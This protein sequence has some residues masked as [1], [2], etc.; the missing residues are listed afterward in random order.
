MDS[1]R[2][3]SNSQNGF[4]PPPAV[5][6]AIEAVGPGRFNARLEDGTVLAKSSARPF[7]DACLRLLAEGADPGQTA[8]LRLGAYTL[9]LAPIGAAAVASLYTDAV[10]DEIRRPDGTEHPANSG[11]PAVLVAFGLRILRACAE[12]ESPEGSSRHRTTLA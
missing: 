4:R 11:A 8:A 2:V 3:T 9:R 6:I 7:A 12:P 10:L 1:Q 5:V